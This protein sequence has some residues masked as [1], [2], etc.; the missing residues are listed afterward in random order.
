MTRL[1][2]AYRP[3]KYKDGGAVLAEDIVAAPR[4]EPMA[5]P[6]ATDDAS[7]VFQQ[8]INNLRRAEETQRQKSAAPPPPPPSPHRA[9]MMEKFRGEG[10][11][12]SA[13]EFLAD[14]E[15]IVRNPQLADQAAAAA[16]NEGHEP[17]TPGFFQSVKSHF[18][19]LQQHDDLSPYLETAAKY[20]GANA[21][22]SLKEAADLERDVFNRS[23]RIVS[24]PV[25]REAGISWSCLLYTSDAADE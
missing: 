1:K 3:K 16:R 18:N 11:S 2:S 13:V 6:D 9:A 15:A 8:Q 4:S 17:D 25:S 10:L 24:A 19:E 12:E 7:A 5:V 21:D 20:V 22:V 23:A 14:N